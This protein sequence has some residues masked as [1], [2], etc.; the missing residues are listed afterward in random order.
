MAFA[1]TQTE[2]ERTHIGQGRLPMAGVV[3]S[4]IT[5]KVMRA[6]HLSGQFSQVYPI[7]RRYVAERCFGKPV[8]LESEVIRS[9]LN[10]VRLQEGIARYLGGK[11]GELTVEIQ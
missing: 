3:L 8:N 7:V 4:S 6:A 5:N 9:H 2:V 1:I 10:D 11:I